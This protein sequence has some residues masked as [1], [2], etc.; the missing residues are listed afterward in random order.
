MFLALALA[1]FS[2]DA[3]RCKGRGDVIAITLPAT[4]DKRIGS[5]AVVKGERWASVVDDQHRY[6]PFH[7][8]VRRLTL[9]TSSQLGAVDGRTMRAFPT[10][11]TYRIVFADNL[12]TEP[13]NMIALDCL[14]RVR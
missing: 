9:K 12:E 7:R 8:G 10:A 1:S 11:G 6:A 4:M 2:D 13:D 14:V 5:M 3:L